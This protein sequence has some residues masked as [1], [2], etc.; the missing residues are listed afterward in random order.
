MLVLLDLVRGES[1][2]LLGEASSEF[3]GVANTCGRLGERQS[4]LSSANVGSL[5]ANKD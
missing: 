1:N 5:K 2:L 4:H 3:I